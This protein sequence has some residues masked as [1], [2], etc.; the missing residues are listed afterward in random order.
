[1]SYYANINIKNQGKD[2]DL[3]WVYYSYNA[4]WSGISFDGISWKGT[5]NDLYK[6]VA[7]WEMFYD[8][9]HPEGLSPYDLFPKINLDLSEID[10]SLT[11]VL[12][13]PSYFG[14]Y[15][16][17][18]EYSILLVQNNIVQNIGYVK[19]YYNDTEFTSGEFYLNW[20]E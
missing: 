11:D 6:D 17:Y 18:V 10:S 13:V 7:S 12:Y 19:L 8:E 2:F 14:S 1:M 20:G 5:V 16:Q 4:G 3:S 9:M 15:Y